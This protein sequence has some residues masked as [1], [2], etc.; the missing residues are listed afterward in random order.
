MTIVVIGD[1]TGDDYAGTDDTQIE[2]GAP[3]TN[4]DSLIYFETSKYSSGNWAH[5]LLRF[6]G[7]SNITGPVTVNDAYI[8]LTIGD[9]AGANHTVSWYRLLRTWVTTEA[10]WNIYSTGNN[11]GTAGGTNATDRSGTVSAQAI[12]ISTTIGT[13]VDFTGTQID[14]DV[15]DAINGVVPNDGWHGE[16]T[17]GSNDSGYRQWRGEGASDGLRPYLT[18]DYTASSGISGTIAVTLANFTS[19]ISGYSTHTGTIAV[20]LSNFTSAIT[21]TKTIVGSI[22]QTLA[23]FTSSISGSSTV[24]GTIAVVLDS[25]TSA[26]SGAIGKVGT[27]GVTLSNFTSAISG[28]VS[29]GIAKARWFVRMLANKF[30][31][32]ITNLRAS[33]KRNRNNS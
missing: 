7:L 14:Q 33:M 11:W 22:A 13:V 16:R 10:T 4:R 21:G 3:T 28:S 30:H 5:A 12:N 29:G 20:T 17:D 1:N 31:F 9:A 23:D 18:V 8:S 26:I 32:G 19:A 6:S 15:E 27:I 24:T 25:L 2:E